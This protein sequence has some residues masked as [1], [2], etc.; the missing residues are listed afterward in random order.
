M[1]ENRLSPLYEFKLA[2]SDTTGFFTGYASTFGGAPDSY[3]DVVARGAFLSSL[4]NHS[5]KGSLPAMLWAHQSDEPIG[6][7]I[8]LKEDDHGL[9]VEGKLTIGTKRGAEAYALMNDEALALS[10]GYRIQPNGAEYQGSTRILKGVD[11]FEISAVALPANPAARVTSVKLLKP[12]NIRDFEAALRDAC[13][14]SVREAKR[15]ASVGWPVLQRR[16]DASDEL[17]IIA[18]LFNRAATEIQIQ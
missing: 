9:A 10:I 3:G 18:D 12:L 1:I 6:R 5:T 11:L 8:S 17:R 4:A 15:V 14:L 7:W 13:G 16:D 2:G